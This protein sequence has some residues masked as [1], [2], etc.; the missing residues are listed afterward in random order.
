MTVQFLSRRTALLSSPAA[1][2][3][4]RVFYRHLNPDERKTVSALFTLDLAPERAYDLLRNPRCL[5]DSTPAWFNLRIRNEESERTVDRYLSATRSEILA[6]SPDRKGI[7]RSVFIE[8][9]CTFF[10]CLPCPWTSEV[11]HCGKVDSLYEVSYRQHSGPYAYFAHRHLILVSCAD[12]GPA[13]DRAQVLD[14]IV[15]DAGEPIAN[16]IAGF[17]LRKLLRERAGI[18]NS[19]HGGEYCRVV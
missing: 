5:N 7:E 19:E 3:A 8:Y 1:Y 10:H 17:L 18:L 9:I 11:T 12:T 2:L 13:P 16:Y 15:F 4:W 14:E 6:T